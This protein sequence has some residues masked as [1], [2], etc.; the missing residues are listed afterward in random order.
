MTRV[1]TRCHDRWRLCQLY[2]EFFHDRPQVL[3]ELVGSLLASSD[4]EDLL[5]VFAEAIVQLHGA[6]RR[7]NFL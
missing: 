2:A 7:A 6:F 1:F 4:I 3:Q 5:T